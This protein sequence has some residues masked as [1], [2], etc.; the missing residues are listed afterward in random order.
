MNEPVQTA[1]V[2]VDR[3]RLTRVDRICRLF[4]DV[5]AGEGHTGIL[6]TATVMLILLSYYMIKPIREGWIAMEDLPGLTT[7]EVK[8]YASF[9]QSLILLAVITG[10]DRIVSH[11]PR[12]Q[13][14]QRSTLF[15]V[16]NLTLFWV[17]QPKMFF[18]FI[19]GIG[20]VFYLWVGMF[21]A[22][23]VAQTW[24]FIIDL[25]NNERGRRMLPM[26]AIGATM[27]SVIGSGLVDMIM[28]YK[29]LGP[30][31]L[32]L[33]ANVPLLCSWLLC[34]ATHVDP[35]YERDGEGIAPGSDRVV[36]DKGGAFKLVFGTKHL[37][38]IGLIT[39]L[40]NWVNSNGENLLFRIINEVIIQEILTNEVQDPEMYA[41][42]LKNSIITFY[43][44]FFFWVNM[45]AL[46]IQA[47]VTS[48]LIKYGGMASALL[49]LPLIVMAS[50]VAII[51]MPGLTLIKIMKVVENA[52]DYSISNTAR[53][54][55][56]LPMSTEVKFK[57][58]TTI[59]SLFARCGDGMAALTVMLGVHV[60][61]FSIEDYFY[62][63]LVL[64]VVW[65]ICSIFVVRGYRKIVAKAAKKSIA[66]VVSRA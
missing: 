54:I 36:P 37:F 34:R 55:L 2:F 64:A 39:L 28:G 47:L 63:N 35:R 52:T 32:L 44:Q 29:A 5:R 4:T 7:L 6:M 48:R 33:I 23:M 41:T 14:I 31:S 11:F 50:N 24:A 66:S 21:G 9:A 3:R 42:I 49:L 30:Q 13:I 10:Y 17:F 51:L 57:A 40:L 15:C 12:D 59:D 45:L 65:L 56:W 27:G 19:P 53:N 62:T 61:A 58:K 16:T 8:A 22:F 20:I 43:G 60:F 26:I 38:L 18:D 1:E 25:Y 46:F